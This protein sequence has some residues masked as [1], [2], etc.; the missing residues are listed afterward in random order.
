MRETDP[1]ELVPSRLYSEHAR[2]SVGCV[3]A[4]TEI[5]RKDWKI[6]SNVVSTKDQLCQKTHVVVEIEAI[7]MSRT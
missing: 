1:L 3:R 4:K 5:Y 6:V 2:Y 7:I